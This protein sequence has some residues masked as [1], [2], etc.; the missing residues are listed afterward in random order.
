MLACILPTFASFNVSFSA[1]YSLCGF[2]GALVGSSGLE[3]PTSRL[4]GVRSNL[5]SYEPSFLRL[6]AAL[7]LPCLFLTRSGGDERVRTDDPLLAKQVLS[8]LS[9]T[10]TVSR[11][12]S[13]FALNGCLQHAQNYTVQ[14]SSAFAL[15]SPTPRA[16]TVIS[17]RQRLVLPRK[18]VIQPHLPIRLPCYDFTPVI[19]LTFDS[20]LLLRLGYWL[21][22]LP[23][24]MV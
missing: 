18:E 2:Q 15:P 4:S 22:A 12:S 1:N 13:S 17:L 20:S 9:Y 7:P 5:L 10:P 6:P 14:V 3:P 8:Q 24:P 16:V 19:G 21:R 23:T 11:P